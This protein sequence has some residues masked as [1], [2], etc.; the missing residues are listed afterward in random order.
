[1]KHATALGRCHFD[2]LKI[3]VKVATPAERAQAAKAA[4][5]AVQA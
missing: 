5:Q 3:S 2:R 1:M 4:L